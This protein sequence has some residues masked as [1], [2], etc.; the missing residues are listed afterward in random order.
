MPG[1]N[2]SSTTRRRAGAYYY[3]LR[4]FFGQQL[5][6]PS[7]GGGSTASA[8]AA[9]GLLPASIAAA[10]GARGPAAMQP[11]VRSSASGSVLHVRRACRRA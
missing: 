5:V 2:D 8:A 6:K 10:P 9:H 3:Q 7:R 4:E 11:L 1:L